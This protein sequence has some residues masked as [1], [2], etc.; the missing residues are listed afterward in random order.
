MARKRG[1]TRFPSR[2]AS[3]IILSRT[4]AKADHIPPRSLPHCEAARVYASGGN[5][6]RKRNGVAK[7]APASRCR[8]NRPRGPRNNAPDQSLRTPRRCS[9]TQRDGGKHPSSSAT[10]KCQA[11]GLTR[12]KG[13]RDEDP[14][15]RSTDC[16]LFH[17][18][19]TAGSK[20]RTNRTGTALSRIACTRD[21]DLRVASSRGISGGIVVGFEKCRKN[22]ELSGD[23]PAE[24]DK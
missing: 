13:T 17:S 18:L 16:Y 14:G 2:R 9:V 5:K 15:A 4:F 3:C 21:P 8:N 23:V 19:H 11:A 22:R 7:K 6:R 20:V 10:L 1:T 24:E 12:W